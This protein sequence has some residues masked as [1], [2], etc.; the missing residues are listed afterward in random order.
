MC[1][2]SL[3]Q[4]SNRP[5]RK[6]VYV[7]RVTSK[8]NIR[9]VT[10]V[11]QQSAGDRSRSLA[12]QRSAIDRH[13]FGWVRQQSRGWWYCRNSR[14][15]GDGVGKELIEK[16]CAQGIEWRSRDGGGEESRLEKKMS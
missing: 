5:W 11:D 1:Y 3:S 14:G 4:A 13:G 2:A 8:F 15:Y 10:W 9:Y 6:D 7:G 16:Q 12:G